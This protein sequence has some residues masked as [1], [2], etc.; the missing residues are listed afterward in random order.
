MMERTS[1]RMPSMTFSVNPYFEGE[2]D[3]QKMECV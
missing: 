3:L 2:F 1:T